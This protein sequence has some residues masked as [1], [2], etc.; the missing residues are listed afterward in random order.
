[1][2]NNHFFGRG[3]L[4]K[5]VKL[6]GTGDKQFLRNTIAIN[7]KHGDSESTTFVDFVIFG[8]GAETF[9]KYT[10]KGD[11]VEIVGKLQNSEYTDKEGNK[12]TSTSIVVREFNFNNLKKSSSKTSSNSAPTE[13]QPLNPEMDI[14]EMFS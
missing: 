2:F 12:R 9:A 3:N 10:Q 11:G 4:V 13:E 8:K 5:E 6:E 14:D 7:E 1:M